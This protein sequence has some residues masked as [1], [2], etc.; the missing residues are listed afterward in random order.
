MD[1]AISLKKQS[2]Q[3]IFKETLTPGSQDFTEFINHLCLASFTDRSKVNET[4]LRE[5]IV[6]KVKKLAIDKGFRIKMPYADRLDKNKTRTIN[7]YCHMSKSANRKLGS[8]QRGCQFRVIYKMR[9]V[10]SPD[11]DNENAN[12]FELYRLQPMHSHLLTL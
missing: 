11:F 5:F 6:Q 10:D 4:Y 1:R 7:F 3:T 2:M 12:L 9:S 8:G